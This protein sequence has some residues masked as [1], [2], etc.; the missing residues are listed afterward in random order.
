M[1]EDSFLQNCQT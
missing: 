1:V